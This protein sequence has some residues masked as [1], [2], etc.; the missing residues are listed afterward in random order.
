MATGSPQNVHYDPYDTPSWCGT[1]SYAPAYD[2]SYGY[3]YG[4]YGPSVGFAYGYGPRYYGGYGYVA[5]VGSTAGIASMA[6]LRALMRARLLG[7]ISFPEWAARMSPG[8]DPPTSPKAFTAA[9]AP[10]SVAG[11]STS[12]KVA[13]PGTAYAGCRLN[14][15]NVVRRR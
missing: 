11:G 3:D 13:V 6:A 5:G 15:S 14:E 8:W 12:T 4:V 9:W 2:Y 10:T 7:P 1:Y